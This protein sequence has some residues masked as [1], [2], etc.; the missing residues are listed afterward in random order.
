MLISDD[1]DDVFYI[2]TCIII[3]S[4]GITNTIGRVLSGLLADRPWMNSLMLNNVSM[5]VAGVA[6]VL[7]PFCTTFPTLVLAALMFGLMTCE[8]S[9]EALSLTPYLTF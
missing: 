5:L 8:Y 2:C 7:T 4:P 3:T 9:T 6:M 1:V